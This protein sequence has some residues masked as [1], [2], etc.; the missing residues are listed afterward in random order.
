MGR[1][2]T[3]NTFHFFNHTFILDLGIE[4]ASI[5]LALTYLFFLMR[6]NKICWFFGIASSLLGIVLFYKTAL[7]SEALLYVYYV[8]I[9]IYGYI[10][11]SKKRDREA[12]SVTWL[13]SRPL[14]IF[15]GLSIIGGLVLGFWFKNYTNADLPYFDAFTTSFSFMASYLEAK[16]YINAWVFWIFINGANIAL[17]GTKLLY[18]Y[19]ILAFIYF[20]FSVIGYVQ[21]KKS[22]Q[23]K[24]H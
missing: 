19:A 20:V 3:S 7:Y 13:K 6:Q 24:F 12:L 11:W 15:L 1:T 5:A 8:I 9:G 17:Y 23:L 4:I 21:W 16:K 18:G 2:I 14:L 22:Y 10:L